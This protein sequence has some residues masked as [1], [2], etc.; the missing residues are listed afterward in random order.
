MSMQAPPYMM[1]IK[2][3]PAILAK[4]RDAGT[5]PK[6]NV[7]FLKS[8]L[9]FA[10][11]ADRGIVAQLKL[12]K[13]ISDDGTPLERYNQ[14]RGSEGAGA[15]AAG[16]KD[17]Y[18]EVFLA[19]QK[20]DTRSVDQLKE[21]F[22]SLTGKGETVAQKMATTFK[23]LCSQADFSV[24]VEP[25]EVVN[26]EPEAD[27][28][29]SG[30]EPVKPKPTPKVSSPTEA[31]LTLRHDIHVHL[32]ATSDVAVYKAIFRAINDELTD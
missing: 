16:I 25:E 15:L 17:G 21:M 11:S 14:F 18:S 23:A 27:A 26:L 3:V 29:M 1:S 28:G 6:F 13:F 8:S 2:N 22:K 30:A 4:I 31:L 19:D 32:P 12:L 10:S 24:T 7:E 9:G 20:A 5:P